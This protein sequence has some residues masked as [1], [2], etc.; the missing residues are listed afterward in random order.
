MWEW[1]GCHQKT[2]P[3]SSRGSRA[4]TN[5]TKRRHVRAGDGGESEINKGGGSSNGD[6]L[7]RPC[8]VGERLSRSP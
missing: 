6:G 5:A 7:K 4:T 3:L 1:G 8:T 2:V